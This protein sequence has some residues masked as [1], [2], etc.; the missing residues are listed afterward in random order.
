MVSTMEVMKDAAGK[1]IKTYTEGGKAKHECPTCHI[2]VSGRISTCPKCGKEIPAK[3]P[4]ATARKEKADRPMF[5]L[6]DALKFANDLRGFV[7]G[8]GGS[9][10]A[11]TLLE[12]I[13]ALQAQAGCPLSE[14]IDAIS[15]EE[16]ASKKA[17][18]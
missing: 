11:K 8:H 1:E 13:E 4:K 18:G 9:K 5:G 14:A 15:S 16:S 7:A 17:A 10:K 12:T 3:T 6:L 2:F